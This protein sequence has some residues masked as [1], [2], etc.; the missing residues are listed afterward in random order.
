ML[1]SGSISKSPFA[2]PIDHVRVQGIALVHDLGEIAPGDIKWEAGRKVIGSQRAKRKKELNTL[3]KL[4]KGLEKKEEYLQLLREFNE[5]TTP[6]AKFLKQ[7]EKLEMVIQAFVY[8]QKGYPRKSLNQ[9][10]ENTEKYL[11]GQ[12]LEPF[13]R[14]LQKMRETH[15]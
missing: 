5:Q 15:L 7:F 11:K 14:E 8:E 9:F 1:S 3:K 6:E 12:E 4:F 10:W 2:S 13:F